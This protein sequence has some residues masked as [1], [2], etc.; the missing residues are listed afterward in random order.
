MRVNEQNIKKCILLRKKET[1][2][3][4]NKSVRII[5]LLVKFKENSLLIFFFKKKKAR[6]TCSAANKI[7]KFFGRL[8]SESKLVERENRLNAL[9]KL[10]KLDAVKTK[11]EFFNFVTKLSLKVRYNNINYFYVMSTKI[12]NS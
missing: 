2:D 3:L 5:N 6:I 4:F 11:R 10:L 7:K 9:R 12:K 8:S 1:L